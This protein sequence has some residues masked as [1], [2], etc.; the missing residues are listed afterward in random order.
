M[1]RK[2]KHLTTP[3]E[4]YNEAELL[5]QMEKKKLG[6]PATR[7]DIIEKL[8]QSDSLDRQG[9]SLHPTQ[10]AWQLIDLVAEE[11]R[12]PDLTTE[13]GGKLEDISRGKGILLT[14]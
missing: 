3:P 5:F 8:L 4:R 14:F 6:T 7:A 9:K 12:S 13:W 2:E 1:G 10:K 11:L